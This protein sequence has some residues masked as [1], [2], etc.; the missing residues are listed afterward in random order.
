MNSINTLNWCKVCNYPRKRDLN[1][2]KL[3]IICTTCGNDNW[4]PKIYLNEIQKMMCDLN[5]F[6][7]H[8]DLFLKDFVEYWISHQN[9]AKFLE[10]LNYQ[11]ETGSWYFNEDLVKEP[12]TSDFLVNFTIFTGTPMHLGH[13]FSDIE[14]ELKNYFNKKKQSLNTSFCYLFESTVIDI[15]LD[16]DYEDEDELGD[17]SIKM[18]EKEDRHLYHE[19]TM[20]KLSKLF[21]WKVRNMFNI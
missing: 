18:V 5:L 17:S 16:Y 20:I 3:F 19:T 6:I 12:E 13:Y 8:L 10:D 14:N 4:V 11:I 7:K 2:K 9:Q 1:K 15:M 21:Y